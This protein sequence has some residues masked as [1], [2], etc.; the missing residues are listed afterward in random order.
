M[1]PGRVSNGYCERSTSALLAE[2][3]KGEVQSA[4]QAV[5]LNWE[6][7]YNIRNLNLSLPAFKR[8]LDEFLKLVPDKPSLPGPNYCQTAKSNSIED[9]LEDLRRKEIYP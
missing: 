8:R 9:Q 2:G 6:Y 7:R 4:L 5:G 1:K 3:F